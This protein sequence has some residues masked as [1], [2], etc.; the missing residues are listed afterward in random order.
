MGYDSN[1]GT[2]TTN[3]YMGNSGK[4]PLGIGI[5]SSGKI[6][7]ANCT[8]N[9][10]TA[11][12]PTTGAFGFYPNDVA[13]GSDLGGSL[14]TYSDFTGNLRAT[15]T[16]PQGDY[17]EVI[18]GCFGP[19]VS[20]WDFLTWSLTAQP[21]GSTAKFQVRV[22]NDP[23]GG[24]WS[25]WYPSEDTFYESSPADLSA[26]PTAIDLCKPEWFW[27]RMKATKALSPSALLEPASSSR[28]SPHD[29]K[30]V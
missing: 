10:L 8:T 11:L 22:G 7:T 25:Q 29:V 16:D 14:Y 26:I 4:A 30:N 19:N 24:V 15:F 3:I 28:V 1:T 18:D 27:S 17:K 6:W 12:D 5:G 21:A 20:S 13:G 2:R 23:D 9:N